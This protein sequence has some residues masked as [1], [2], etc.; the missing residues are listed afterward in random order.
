MPAKLITSTAV[1]TQ[2]KAYNKLVYAA[3]YCSDGLAAKYFPSL[4]NSFWFWF[5]IITEQYW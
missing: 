3:K 2:Y 1:S 5:F 4:N